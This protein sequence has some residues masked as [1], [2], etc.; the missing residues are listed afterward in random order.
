VTERDDGLAHLEAAR[1]LFAL[2][3]RGEDEPEDATGR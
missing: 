1:T 3:D 2:D